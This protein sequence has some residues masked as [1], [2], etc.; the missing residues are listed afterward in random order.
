MLS[1]SAYRLPHLRY[2]SRWW[3]LTSV[4]G[5]C[6]MLGIRTYRFPESC[7][8]AQRRAFGL[9]RHTVLD[10]RHHCWT[11]TLSRANG[12]RKASRIALDGRLLYMTRALR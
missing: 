10:R 3:Y 7:V 8:A 2:G 11:D 5:V 6:T 1:I 12:L 4:V 9:N